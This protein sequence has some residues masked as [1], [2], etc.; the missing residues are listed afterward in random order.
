MCVI[1]APAQAIAES[2]VAR[3]QSAPAEPHG[4]LSYAYAALA[5]ATGLALAALRLAG[6]HP[7]ALGPSRV[8]WPLAPG[9]SL[10][11]MLLLIVAGAAAAAAAT[12]SLGGAAA[13]DLRGRALASLAN[14]GAQLMLVAGIWWAL[15]GAV[16]QHGVPAAGAAVPLGGARA[17]ALGALAMAIG[18]PLVQAGGAV[19]SAIQQWIS[20]VAAPD[21][22]HR[23][24]E[25][26][27]QSGDIAWIAATALV[28]VVLAPLVEEILYR[29]ALQQALHG[30]G[31][32]RTIAILGSSAL[33]AAAHWGS[34]V[35]GS[36]AGAL[37]MLL[38]LGLI[39]GW[40]YE[41]TGSMWAP[42]TAHALFNAANLAIFLT[43]R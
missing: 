14:Y 40:A 38:L 12:Q 16:R 9:P 10:F 8:R 22:A 39:F 37:V 33:F 41:R 1:A 26:L 32:P 7:L 28:A 18:W 17:A 31:M 34:L 5:V 29:G 30:L 4:W 19:A 21:T 25:A 20:G 3:A 13:D 11:L 43:Q 42:F 24:L 23:T 15:A 2:A 6:R 35:G 27:G 36:E